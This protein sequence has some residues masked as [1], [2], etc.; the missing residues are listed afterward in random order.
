MSRISDR[1]DV[2]KLFSRWRSGDPVFR[3]CAGAALL[4]AW[5]VGFL[6]FAK[7][8]WDIDLGPVMEAKL[9]RLID[10]Y[11]WIGVA[12]NLVLLVLLAA[13]SG[14]W[15]KRTPVP[16]E[17]PIPEG[18]H[19]HRGWFWG[20]TIAAVGCTLF[21]GAQRIGK[22]LWDDEDYALRNAILGSYKKINGEPVLQELQWRETFF[23][24]R[25]PTNHHLQTILS[26]QSNTAWR[27]LAK[28]E[29]LQ[30]SEVALRL[31]A[32]IAGC[33]AVV[34]LAGLFRYL[35]HP[36]AGGAAALLVSVHPWFIRYVT[37]VRG[38]GFL[39]LF[40]PLGLLL[41]LEAVRTGRWKWWAGYAVVQFAT[42]YV[43]PS[44]VYW[45]VVQV[46]ALAVLMLVRFGWSWN[47]LRL[48]SRLVVANVLA[49]MCFIQLMAP[50]IP[51]LAHYLDKGSKRGPMLTEWHLNT[52]AFIGS[53]I[54]WEKG[55]R[56]KGE[57]PSLID[58]AQA[59]PVIFWTAVAVFS[60]CAWMGV[61]RLMRSAPGLVVLAVFSVPLCLAYIHAKTTAM[62]LYEWYQL[63][64]I[65]LWCGGMA[66][67]F[68][69]IGRRLA[70]L[71]A[72]GRRPGEEIPCGLHAWTVVVL[73]G[74]FAAAL[75][76][77]R[78]WYFEH[79]VQA[80]R[81]SVLLTRK[82]LDPF[83]PS[84]KEVLTAGYAGL[85]A[86]YDPN[87]NRIRTVADFEKLMDD[88]RT[89]QRPLYINIGGEWLANYAYP[90]VHAITTDPARFTLIKRFYGVE[91]WTDRLVY[92]F[93]ETA[94]KHLRP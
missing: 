76:E 54:P 57:H 83:D 74:L 87:V 45:L 60:V 43:W 5:M 67:G 13:T 3:V 29:G 15:A 63:P 68:D 53:G 93:N 32:W 71:R 22:S 47:S 30:F 58:Q 69:A 90:E 49:A 75:T 46:V 77:S 21:F 70:A 11:L 66:L 10:Y 16:V 2:A 39:L 81:E 89:T 14:F 9:A 73:A 38:Y 1:A 33:A 86:I 50:C 88:A 42:M 37:E 34:A 78:Q 62:Y 85:S 40:L 41:G 36:I 28:P 92:V 82:T 17:A 59:H 8:P 4:A 84:Q 56:V 25:K 23:R 12:V 35:G 80:N 55:S 26:R 94:P 64:A 79:S 44:A 91:P 24:Y 27:K 18:A 51:Q 20:L 7:K 48:L 61:V 19:R 72:G 6:L 31:P 52:V 65:L